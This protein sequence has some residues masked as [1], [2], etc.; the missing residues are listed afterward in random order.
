[1]LSTPYKNFDCNVT[2]FIHRRVKPSS[3]KNELDTVRLPHQLYTFE[4]VDTVIPG[5]NCR[6]V[7]G[8]RH[9]DGIG[10]LSIQGYD[11]NTSHNNNIYTCEEG[12]SPNYDKNPSRNIIRWHCYKC[13]YN[14]LPLNYKVQ[15]DN[16]PHHG[17]LYPVNEIKL[18]DLHDSKT[19]LL[20]IGRYPDMASI[21]SWTFCCNIL[22]NHEII[23]THEEPSENDFKDHDIGVLFYAL[24]LSASNTSFSDEAEDCI[25]IKRWIMLHS[26]VN[27]NLGDL[28]Q[29]IPDEMHDRILYH[30]ENSLSY[31]H[32]CN[33]T[34]AICDVMKMLV[35]RDCTLE[36]V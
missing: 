12:D 19:T 7:K 9:K 13:L 24:Q 11:E 20:P 2:S 25:N 15:Y 6:V 30:L 33:E 29:K 35:S 4:D 17:C 14:D 8:G 31:T 18:S 28:S 21:P 32:F 16:Y 1:M 10:G 5:N 23:I 34:E 3:N 26:N 27:D 36:K 22:Q